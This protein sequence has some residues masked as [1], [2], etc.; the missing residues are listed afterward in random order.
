[1]AGLINQ[2]LT[3]VKGGVR[4]SNLW[5]ILWWA[6]TPYS[7][8]QTQSCI[9]GLYH[10]WVQSERRGLLVEVKL[11]LMVIMVI[12]CCS[13]LDLSSF[14]FK[15]ESFR[16]KSPKLHNEK[17]TFFLKKCTVVSALHYNIAI[18]NPQLVEVFTNFSAYILRKTWLT[19]LCCFV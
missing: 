3:S 19:P 13:G 8:F 12:R 4:C 7:S 2:T 1:M 17:T 10:I 15:S 16:F 5:S 6:M 14:R 11:V 9:K 18:C